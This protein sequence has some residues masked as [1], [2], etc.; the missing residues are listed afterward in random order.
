MRR[1]LLLLIAIAFLSNE[2]T[3]QFRWDAGLSLGASNYLGDI[4]GTDESRRDFI[5]DVKLDQTK[6]V[7]GV[8]V[9]YKMTRTIAVTG[10]FAYA[11]VSGWDRDT[12]Y[13]PRRARN[14]NFKNNIKELSLRGEL[15]LYSDNDVGGKGYYN[16]DFRLYGFL[17]VAGI[18][19][20]PQGFLQNPTQDLE[21]GWYD[22]R[23]LRTEGQEKEYGQFTVAFPV[24][25]GLYFTHQKKWRF[26]WELGYRLTA[27]DYLDDISSTYA[28]D[29][30]LDSDLAAALANQTT[31]EVIQETFGDPAMIY[32]YHYPENYSGTQKNPRGVE[33]N[34]DG[35]LTSQFTVGRVLKERSRYAKSKHAWLKGRKKRRKAR[36]K[37]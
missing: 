25:I 23:E 12:E 34:R 22:L 1:I 24:G 18:M 8:H 33:S 29:S 21:Q 31:P 14:L 28:L 4:G 15:T 19:H 26:G 13:A 32:N 9:R 36:A 17:G 27:T 20:N 7:V 10:G 30:E 5:H 3:A 11:Q 37:F 2:G 35:F 6:Y 16:P